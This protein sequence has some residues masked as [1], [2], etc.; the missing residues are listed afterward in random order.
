MRNKSPLTSLL[1]LLP[2]CVLP[3]LSMA[4]GS[5]DGAV[6]RQSVNPT[7]IAMFLVFVCVT[8]YISYWASKRTNTSAEFYTA[9]GGISGLQNGAAIAGDFMSAASFLGI[10]ALIYATGIDGMTLALAA[11][12]GWP[13]MLILLS[14]RVRNLGKVTFTDVVALRLEQTRTRII[15]VLG[16]VSVVVMYLIAQMVG[17]GK[18]IELLFGLPYEVAVII[19][20]ALVMAYVAFGGMLATT[21]V[22]IVKALLLLS[23]ITIIGILV[24]HSVDFNLNELLRQAVDKH[25]RGGDILTNGVWIDDPIQILTLLVSMMFGTLGLPHILMRLFTVPNMEESRK[26]AFYASVFIGYFFL[27]LIVAGFGTIVFV[28]G[29]PEYTDATG[30]LLGGGNMAAIHLANAV[31]GDLLMG[32]MSA[33]AFATIL[34]VV[35][36]LTV[37]GSAAISH[38]LYAQ[39]LCKGKPDPDKEIRLT[40]IVTL[41]LGLLAVAL[42]I[43]FQEQNVAVIATLPMVVAASVNLPILLL[44]LYWSKL[45]TRGAVAGAIV[46]FVSSIGLIIVGPKVWVDI[47]GFET[48][49]FPYDY[50]ALFTMP[51]AFFAIWIV[52]HMDNSERAKEDRANFDNLVQQSETGRIA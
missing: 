47:L 3:S 5:I 17:A 23:G 18:L 26:S 1:F 36:G 27:L 12:A 43:V 9:G 30:K 51:A 29:N 37:A 11:F 41:V 44:S 40:R 24:L 48:A 39:V 38:D 13:M 10:T 49:L 6:E 2:A 28:M 15:A 50:P 21:W 46:G 34:A 8:L 22:Q 52:S 32:F 31:G 42:G 33:V 19:V 45:S 25:P 35:A 20:A 14:E 4:A 16:S 7:A